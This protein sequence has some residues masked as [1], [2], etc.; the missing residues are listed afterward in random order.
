MDPKKPI[1]LDF[2]S[3]VTA[4]A[5]KAALTISKGADAIA[6]ERISVTRNADSTVVSVNVNGGLLYD[7]TVYTLTLKKD[8][9]ADIY[10]CGISE[11]ITISFTTLESGGMHIETAS[12]VAAGEDLQASVTVKNDSG[13]VADAWVV[14]AAYKGNAMV[15]VAYADIDDLADDDIKTETLTLTKANGIGET[16]KVFIWD[17]RTTLQPYHAAMPLTI[18]SAK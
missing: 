5:V 15:D 8:A 9:F 13:A 2:K 7:K 10:G 3:P 11:D 18:I 6:S 1:V 16:Y 4:D 14:V 17:A 12:M